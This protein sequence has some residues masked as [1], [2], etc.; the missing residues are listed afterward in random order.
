VKAEQKNTDAARRL[1]EKNLELA[2][3]AVDDVFVQA[4]EDPAME[5]EE[6]RG[7]RRVLLEKALHYYE[8]VRAQ[9]PDDPGLLEEEAENLFKVA[10][11]I[12]VIGRKADALERY[13]RALDA[14][15]RLLRQQPD[16]RSLQARLARTYN[17]MAVLQG[18]IGELEAA[19]ASY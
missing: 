19:E 8:G 7:G 16:S 13:R 17:N 10:K 2:R 5:Q 4:S 3:T 18:Q 1:A 11:I 9:R 15:E 6:M 12:A 14:Q